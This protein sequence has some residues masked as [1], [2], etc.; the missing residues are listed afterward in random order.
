MGDPG[1]DGKDVFQVWKGLQ[2]PGRQGSPG[3]TAAD[4]RLFLEGVLWRVRTGARRRDL[5]SEFGNW[6]S[7]FVRFRRR[8]ANGVFEGIFKELPGSFDLEWAQVEGA[9]LRAHAKGAGGKGGAT[10]ATA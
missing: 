7:V 1:A 10:R 6:N 3:R 9:A 5:P 8:A 2:P 4:S